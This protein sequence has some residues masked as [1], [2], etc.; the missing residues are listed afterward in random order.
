M[1]INFNYMI[2]L[3]F[4]IISGWVGGQAGCTIFEYFGFLT[5]RLP[6]LQKTCVHRVGRKRERS[7][8]RGNPPLM[9]DALSE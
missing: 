4:Y 6:T 1:H 3:Y 7:C 5:A 2:F 8:T 9:V